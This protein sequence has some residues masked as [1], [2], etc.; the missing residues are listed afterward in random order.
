MKMGLGGAY[1]AL[2]AMW[3]RPDKWPLGTTHGKHRHVCATQILKPERAQNVGA[4]PNILRP[5]RLQ[6]LGGTYVAVFAMC[7]AE[8]PLVGPRPHR[9][10][11]D[12]CATQPHF[13]GSCGCHKTRD[14][15]AIIQISTNQH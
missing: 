12:V 11:R 9:K 2:F 6:D 14:D 15:T 8:G 1:I 10:K 5:F 3:A 7:C 4:S 13:H